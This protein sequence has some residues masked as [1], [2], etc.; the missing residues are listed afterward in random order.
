[1]DPDLREALEALHDLRQFWL[2]QVTQTHAGA[3]HHNPMWLRVA[4]VLNK[5]GM[6]D[7][8]TDTGLRYFRDDPAYRAI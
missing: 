7:H 8:T 6:N 2:D 4:T 5:H 1:M 3:S